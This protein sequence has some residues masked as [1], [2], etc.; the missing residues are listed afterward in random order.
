LERVGRCRTPTTEL[1]DEHGDD[2][3]EHG[4]ENDDHVGGGARAVW[5]SGAGR[6]RPRSEGSGVEVAAAQRGARPARYRPAREDTP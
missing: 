1:D 2:D 5:A 6:P 4:D 3:H